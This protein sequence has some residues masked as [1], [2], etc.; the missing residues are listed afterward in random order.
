MEVIWWSFSLLSFNLFSLFFFSCFKFQL[1]VFFFFFT[2]NFTTNVIISLLLLFHGFI[3]FAQSIFQS[4]IPVS[5]KKKNFNSNIKYH[6]TLSCCRILGPLLRIFTKHMLDVVSGTQKKKR[7]IYLFSGHESNIAA[8]LH[9]LELYYPHVPEYSSSII[10][11]LH[12]IEGTHY[13]K[14]RDESCINRY[15]YFLNIENNTFKGISYKLTYNL[16][17]GQ[18]MI[19]LWTLILSHMLKI[20][21]L[22]YYQ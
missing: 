3:D 5:L 8:V 10:V 19:L 7:K 22:N 17:S 12:N 20:Y 21:H 18:F 13:V 9:A 11:E 15:L 4:H 1:L 14:V 6:I 16:D 2:T